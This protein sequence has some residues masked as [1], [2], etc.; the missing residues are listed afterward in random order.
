[1]GAT[2]LSHI[3]LNG[4]LGTELTVAPGQD[5]KIKANWKDNNSACGTCIDF[6][7]TAFARNPAAGCIESEGEFGGPQPNNGTGEVDLGPAPTKGGTYNVVAQF[8]EVRECGELWNASESTGYQ[9]IARV[10]VPNT[11]PDLSL[12]NIASPSPVVSGNTLTYTLT[13]TNT[14]GETANEVSLS[15]QLPESAVFKSMSAT[16]GTCIRKAVEKP[17]TKDGGV[18]CFLG[19]LEGGKTATIMITVT[20]TKPGTLNAKAKVTAS[21]VTSDTDD[22]ETATTTV[23]GD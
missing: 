16:Q 9:A 18:V 10:T 2:T 3:E 1:V 21:N 5:V 22:E 13:V 20:A 6:V 17:K 12:K 23:L 14:G 8:E 7:G 15:D 11:T 19:S 4:V